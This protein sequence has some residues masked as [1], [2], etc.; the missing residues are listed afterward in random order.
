MIPHYPEVLAPGVSFEPADEF[1]G[2]YL[3]SWE[4]GER[5]SSS[6]SAEP[7]VLIGYD[8]QALQIR[9]TWGPPEV[10]SNIWWKLLVWVAGMGKTPS[11]VGR[12]IVSVDL[13]LE[14]FKSEVCRRIPGNLSEVFNPETL[15]GEELPRGSEPPPV[16]D[17]I[18]RLRANVQAATTIAGVIDALLD[19]KGW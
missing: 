4:D 6:Y 1:S 9:E 19:A 18:E 5:C 17:M 8:G 13:S 14:D 2:E 16:D 12:E 10:P 15:A 11:L 7:H 3:T